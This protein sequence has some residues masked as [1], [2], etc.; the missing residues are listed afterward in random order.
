MPGYLAYIP[1]GGLFHTRRRRP[2]RRRHQPLRR[3]VA[4][5][6]RPGAARGQRAALAV[7]RW[8]A[9]GDGARGFLT[10]GGSLANFS[11]LVTA[12]RETPAAGLPARRRLLLRPGAP[13][14][15]EGGDA[16]RLPARERARAAVRRALPPATRGRRGG[17]RRG[18]RG[19]GCT[20]FLLVAI[21]GTDEH[22]RGRPAAG[23]RRASPRA[24]ACGST[25]T[26][27][28]AASSC[29]P[30]AAAPTLAGIERADSVTL[31]PHKG[32]FLPYGTGCL[33]VRDGEA[34]AP[35]PRPAR[36]LP[37]G[38]AAGAPRRRRGE[39]WWDF[40]RALARAVAPVPRPARLAAWL[41]QGAADPDLTRRP[42]ASPIRGAFRTVRP[43]CGVLQRHAR[44]AVRGLEWPA[45]FVP[46]CGTPT[47]PIPCLIP[48]APPVDPPRRPDG[49]RPGHRAARRH[50]PGREG[51]PRQAADHRGRPA[52]HGRPA[53]AGRRLQRQRRRHQ[54]HD[55]DP[56]RAHRGARDARRLLHRRRP[57][58]RAASRRA[59]GRSATAS[60]NTI[61]GEADRIE[62]DG[63]SR[64]RAL[65]RQRRG[66]AAAR[67]RRWPTR[68]PAT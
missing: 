47:C 40:S 18:P 14:A 3:R 57:S 6:A 46:P 21:A 45:S 55:G 11:A 58:A 17:D 61:E 4:G 33:L 27:P 35:R 5:G 10:T 53:Q 39:G 59:S 19:A 31:D 56:R 9:T 60:T 42:E 62:Y 25:S 2:H 68:S 7:R 1:G 54:G 65:H 20:P 41:P 66:A 34:L 30:S 8:S 64:R 32:L 15:A 51:R 16:R 63:K 12:R 26:A 22:R 49:P 28:T 52:G 24:R 37:A 50:R 43:A 67:Q 48:R 29:S 36:R 13:L 44:P 38:A 23:A